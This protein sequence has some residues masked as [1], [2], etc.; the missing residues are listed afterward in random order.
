MATSP[1]Q[2]LKAA[3][4]LSEE[5]RLLIATELL[6]TLPDQLIG[7]SLGDAGFLDELDRRRND[8]SASIPWQTALDQLNNA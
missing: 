6:S 2:I 5:D 7:W 8:G 1:E 3:R 4:T